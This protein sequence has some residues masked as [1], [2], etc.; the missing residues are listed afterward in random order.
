MRKIFLCFMLVLAFCCGVEGAEDKKWEPSAFEHFPS[1]RQKAKLVY[2]DNDEY[3]FKEGY[4]VVDGKGNVFLPF[5]YDEI[6]DL[7]D[8]KL[9]GVKKGDLWG[10]VDEKNNTLV[11]FKYNSA[12]EYKG[13]CYGGI[14]C[15]DKTD[16]YKI[17]NGEESF[18]KTL[19]GTVYVM[20]NGE[21]G[22]CMGQ[23][24]GIVDSELN[25]VTEPQYD[26]EIVFDKLG[27]AIV[28]KNST[29]SYVGENGMTYCTGGDFGIIDRKG[30]TVL[31][32]NYDNIRYGHNEGIYF[33]EPK[34]NIESDIR[35]DLKKWGKWY[36][37]FHL[38]IKAMPL[39]IPCIAVIVFVKVR[40]KRKRFVGD[41]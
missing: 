4:G 12:F 40:R 10:I 25:V 32:M 5:E 14:R 18:L 13:I 39:F 41:T 20:S 2:V 31:G 24:H 23:A 11:D 3:E 9:Y 27:Y 28:C 35:Y 26:N 6:T 21:L 15:D 17:E 16:Y 1:G 7:G 30:R 34:D 36:V 38:F 8:G 19:S 37:M 33:C 29:D 22:Y